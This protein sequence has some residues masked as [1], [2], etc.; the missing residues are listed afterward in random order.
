MN[1]NGHENGRSRSSGLTTD[2]SDRPVTQNTWIFTEDAFL[3]YSPSRKQLTLDQELKTR[4]SIHS[5]LVK[6][7]TTLK[8]DGR[9]IL[10]ATIYVNRF[11]VRYPI[12]TSKYYVASAALAIS[13]KLN[14]NYRP[15]DK[16]ALSACILRNP[17][18]NV[19]PHSDLF[20]T[21]RDQLLYREELILKNL[22]FDLNLTLPYELRDEIINNLE[23]EDG[24]IFYEKKQ[25]I[26][27]NTISFIELLSSLPVSVAYDMRI[28]FGAML[29]V[30]IHEAR[31]KLELDATEGLYVPKNVLEEILG[32]D[33]AL[34]YQCYKYIMLLLKRSASGDP[35]YIS[36]RNTARLVPTLDEHTF[37]DLVSR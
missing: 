37:T 10:A 17:D 23:K 5:F 25:E 33:V 8:V 1:P 20:W 6:L 4:E 2:R 15:P 28:I 36:H 24:S 12:T 19:D 13:C 11:Y 18:K 34:C 35:K 22:N 27:K 14:D 3:N 21:W 26:L 29:I 16:I 30:N 7:G 32:V 31:H 9:T